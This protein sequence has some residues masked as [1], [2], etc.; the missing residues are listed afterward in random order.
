MEM[1]IPT[2]YLSTLREMHS[3]V[4]ELK[5]VVGSELERGSAEKI[6]LEEQLHDCHVRMEELTEQHKTTVESV[7]RRYESTLVETQEAL[8]QQTEAA[9]VHIGRLDEVIQHSQAQNNDLKTKID[10][11][12]AQRTEPQPQLQDL[13]EMQR[14]IQRATEDSESSRSAVR[15]LQEE[16]STEVSQLKE[17]FSVFRIAQD[18][19]VQALEKQVKD[20]EDQLSKLES[21]GSSEAAKSSSVGTSADDNVIELEGH[22]RRLEYSYRAK[23]QELDSVLKSLERN[24]AVRNIQADQADEADDF[25]GGASSTRGENEDQ[26]T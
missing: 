17:Y 7:R 8:E 1:N 24:A 5:R 4:E 12:E 22:L 14:I 23:C 2:R 13:V 26:V 16:H 3:R 18:S 6:S 20:R 11:L 15:A 10:R 9:R 21:S 25:A 19:I